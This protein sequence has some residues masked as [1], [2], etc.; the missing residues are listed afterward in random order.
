[1]HI[2]GFARFGNPNTIVTMNNA[3]LLYWEVPQADINTLYAAEDADGNPY[4]FVHLPLTQ[5]N[6]VTAYGKNLG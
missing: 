3:D 1:M 4:N 6:V 2:D 5:N